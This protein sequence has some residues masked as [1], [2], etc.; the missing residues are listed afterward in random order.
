MYEHKGSAPSV[1]VMQGEYLKEIWSP[2][3]YGFNP[4]RMQ[5][6]PLLILLICPLAQCSAL[7]W[8]LLVKEDIGKNGIPLDIFVFFFMTFCNYKIFFSLSVFANQP[9]VHNGK[10]AG[11]VAVDGDM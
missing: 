4:G 1:E 10:F 2:G 9:T 7:D 11:A 3:R 5:L 8:R 6:D